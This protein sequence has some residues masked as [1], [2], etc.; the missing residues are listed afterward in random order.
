MKCT[1][2]KNNYVIEESFNEESDKIIENTKKA[3]EDLK[4]L[5]GNNKSSTIKKK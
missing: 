5:S 2:C 4:G 1:Y 3:L